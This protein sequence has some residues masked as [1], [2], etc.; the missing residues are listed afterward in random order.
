[1][2]HYTKVEREARVKHSGL[3][4]PYVSYED[5]G[6][7]CIK[8]ISTCHKLATFSKELSLFAMQERASL[9]LADSG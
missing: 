8:L 4:G 2:L 9:M 5:N 6:M 3:L 1:M 7:L